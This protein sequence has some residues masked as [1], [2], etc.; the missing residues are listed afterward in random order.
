M[1]AAIISVVFC[2]TA[3][4]VYFFSRPQGFTGAEGVDVAFE[5]SNSSHPLGQSGI[6]L[7]SVHSALSSQVLHL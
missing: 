7:N 5:G 6:L 2:F 4:A 1:I 3:F